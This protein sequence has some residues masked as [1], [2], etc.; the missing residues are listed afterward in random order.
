MPKF[1]ILLDISYVDLLVDADS[2]AEA[3]KK[4]LQ[5]YKDVR[6]FGGRPRLVSTRVRQPWKWQLKV[7]QPTKQGA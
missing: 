1:R 4:V 7:T 5:H 2:E 3:H 6:P